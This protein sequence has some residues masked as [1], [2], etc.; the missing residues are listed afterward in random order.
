MVILQPNRHK[1]SRVTGSVIQ[2]IRK[3][4]LRFGLVAYFGEG[5]LH[6]IAVKFFFIIG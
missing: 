1:A 4:G 2:R 6:L 5:R 3:L